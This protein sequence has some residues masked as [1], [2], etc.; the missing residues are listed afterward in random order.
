MKKYSLFLGL[1]GVTL[2]LAPTVSLICLMLFLLYRFIFR[3]IWRDDMLVIKISVSLGVFSLILG[4]FLTGVPYVL[5]EIL[6]LSREILALDLNPT[7]NL[8]SWLLG[9]A[10]FWAWS[11]GLFSVAGLVYASKDYKEVMIQRET[12]RLANRFT[13]NYMPDYL[14]DKHQLVLGTTGSGKTSYINEMA[15]RTTAQDDILVIIDGKAD[16]GEFSLLDNASQIA[17]DFDRDLVILNGTNNP[18]FNGRTYNPFLG[19]TVTQAKDLMM[20]LLEDDT[21]KKSS[22]SEHYK[23]MF[24]AYLLSVL[25]V[26]ELL[27]IKFSFSNILDCL[28]FDLIQTELLALRDE[29]ELSEEQFDRFNI[30]FLELERNWDDTK[31]SVTK[32][33]IFKRGKGKEIFEGNSKSWFNVSSVYENNQILLVLID[34]M[35]MLDFA[36]GLAKMV[37]Q[38]VRNFTASRLNGKYHKGQQVRLVMDEFSAY[39]N[40]T[41]LALLA[42]ARSAGVTV[43]LSTQSM[44]DLS[45]LGDDFQQSVIENIN[46]FVVFRQNSPKSAEMVADIIG[47]RQTITQTERTSGGL[48]T[49]EASNTLAREYL[50]NPDEIKALPSQTAFYVAKDENKVYKFVNEWAKGPEKN[51]SLLNLIKK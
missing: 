29:K 33:E 7:D 44:G 14:D 9:V 11:V 10:D 1:L 4:Y 41:M 5:Q 50:I 42:R 12:D 39:A 6:A 23:T 36:Q 30:L 31:A 49:E 13:E 35:S 45:A 18:T 47:T 15:R 26:M 48:A 38:D 8:F 25:E 24:E 22:G 28:N 20:S 2:F 46:R 21:V 3:L 27:G 43:Y 34:E 17:E 19:V 51:R 37:V 32:L 16:T 40:K